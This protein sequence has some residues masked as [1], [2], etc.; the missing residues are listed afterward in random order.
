LFLLDHPGID[1]FWFEFLYTPAVFMVLLVRS[2]WSPA[3]RQ[4]VKSKLRK[5]LKIRA[6][7]QRGI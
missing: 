6:A 5:K 7:R 1:H 3:D 4:L 2:V